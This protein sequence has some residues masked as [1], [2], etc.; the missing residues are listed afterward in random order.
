D[1]LTELGIPKK[2]L[3]EAREKARLREAK[4]P[5]QS[6]GGAPPAP[7][8]FANPGGIT[9]IYAAQSSEVT[10]EREMPPRTENGTVH[11][12]LTYT[13]VMVITEALEKSKEPITYGELARRIQ[14]QYVAWGRTFPTPLIEGG[15]KDR[16]ILGDKVWPGRSSMFLNTRD[17]LK[18]NAGAIHGLT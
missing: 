5:E 14:S 4:K 18:V 16:E 3:D 12:L 13:M 17:G 10:L 7:I 1:P 15:D 9:A 11:G 6:R 8:Q 2:A